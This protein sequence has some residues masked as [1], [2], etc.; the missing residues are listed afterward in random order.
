MKTF[1]VIGLGRFGRSVAEQLISLDCEVLAIDNDRDAVN[2][3]A[4]NV[5]QAVCADAKDENVLKTLGVRNYDCAVVAIG[6]NI[7]DSVLITMNVKELGIKRIVCKAKDSQHKR[8]LE[9]IGADSVIIPEHEA[10]RKMA[11]SL[12]SKRMIDII[13]I[14][15]G[16]SIVDI[17]A[18]KA[19]IGKTIEQLSV[20][21]KYGVNIVAIK[22][23]NDENDVTINPAPDYAFRETDI[24]ALVGKSQHIRKIS[25][26]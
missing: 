16:Y 1:V 25:E 10:G 14:S 26:K 4:N 12:V 17:N 6:D 13:D 23:G 24:V 21:K 2:E 20:R 22:N 19:W 7:S 18:P 11:Y 3:I 5:T 9:K 8:V 15:A